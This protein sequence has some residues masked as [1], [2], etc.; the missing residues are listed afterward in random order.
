VKVSLSFRTRILLI[1]M[2]VALVP[3]ALVGLWIFRSAAR[4]GEALVEN[5]LAL[6]L[7]ATVDRVQENW[8]RLRSDALDLAEDREL[9]EA[10]ASG[11]PLPVSLGNGL[12]GMD[13]GIVSVSVRDAAGVEIWSA[14]RPTE[15]GP[16]GIPR[17]EEPVFSVSQAVWQ[18]LSDQRVGTID[19]EIRAT[20]LLGSG[21]V[22]PEAAGTVIGLFASRTGLSLNPIPFD[23]LMLEAERF[24]WGGEAWLTARR[25]MAEP[26][27]TVVVAASLAP[28]TVPLEEA[29]RNGMVLILVVAAVGLLMAA[30][31][32]RRLTGSL[33]RLSEAADAVAA[34]DLDRRIEAKED[35]E[36]GR[37]A[38]AF[39]AMTAN[40]EETLAE[41]SR[42]KSLAAVGQFAA[43]LAHEIR[44]PLTA[45]RV[46]LQRVESG[47]PPDSALREPHQRALREI[48]RLDETVARTL[49]RTRE[50]SEGNGMQRIDLR[51]PIRAAGDAALPVF[52][53]AGAILTIDLPERL[54]PVNGDK[55]SLE[56]LF[57]NLMQNAAQ[58][59]EPGGR[60]SV[61]AAIDEDSLVVTVT[62]DG[63]GIPEDLQ[64]R[65]FDPLFSTRQEGTGLGLT[66]ARRIAEAHGGEV[67][68]ESG[69]GSGTCVTVRMPM[70]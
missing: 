3:L 35:D 32:T 44:N 22:P 70:V 15:S 16:S 10:L 52:A 40:L 48:T 8:I 36:V 6:A 17:F 30:A 53:E 5:R 64:R 46:D 58:A 25:F 62:D 26:P 59:L 12:E 50:H 20:G 7:E 43:S 42:Q 9:Q 18:G 38:E 56:Q 23:P 11:G 41:L 1:V 67:V 19:F 2:L 57:L 24:Q 13:P 54:L 37:V 49:K 33:V 21:D 55:G 29:S 47:L 34:G 45:I 39:N 4:S 61:R 28:F 51:D 65:V 63:V 14:T 69:P 27:V 66:I 31:L 68:L 60:A